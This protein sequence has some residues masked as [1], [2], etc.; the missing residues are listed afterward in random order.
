M[1]FGEGWSISGI[2]SVGLSVGLVVI[3]NDSAGEVDVVTIVRQIISCSIVGTDGF[4][5]CACGIYAISVDVER[6]SCVEFL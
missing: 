2:S 6:K 5:W 1:F 4:A 3:W